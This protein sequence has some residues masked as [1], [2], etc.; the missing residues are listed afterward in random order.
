MALQRRR[1]GR[2]V[3]RTARLVTSGGAAAEIDAPQENNRFPYA[4]AI[5]V[6]AILAAIGS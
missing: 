5:A 1:L 6:G 2:T 3:T 4:P